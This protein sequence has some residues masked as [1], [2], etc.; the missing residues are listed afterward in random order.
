[1]SH[2]LAQNLNYDR[3]IKLA[4]DV[5]WVGFADR[6]RGLYCNP[7][8]IIDQGEGIL[9]D[10]GS[11]PEFSVVMMKVLQTALAP[12]QISTLIYQH[13]DPDLCGSVANF[14]ALIGRADLRVISKK[15]N[16]VFI[17]YY[18]VQSKLLCIDDMEHRLVLKSGRTLRFIT[19]PYAHTPGSFMTLDERTGILFTSDLLGGFDT[20]M[21]R[22]LFKELQDQCLSCTRPLPG[23]RERC[24]AI[25]AICP[26][27]EITEFHK[28][29][30][31]SN[32][33]LRRACTQIGAAGASLVAPQHGSLW[34]RKADVD[35]I[36]ARLSAL[37]D[38]GIDGFPDVPQP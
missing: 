7:F 24:A 21:E 12:N 22:D 23:M 8:L 14:E 5:Y 4:D 3:P 13:Y 29:E 15:E 11:R 36:L 2:L 37:E 35:C 17:R 26:L 10:A 34:H 27:S 16:N 31:P 18:G 9:I 1:M 6:T 32:R 19:T 33:A 30:M 25:S 20:G 28:V 38:V